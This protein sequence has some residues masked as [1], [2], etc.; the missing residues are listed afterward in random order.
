MSSKLIAFCVALCNLSAYGQQVVPNLELH[1]DKYAVID[2]ALLKVTYAFGR[3][4][5][6]GKPEVR[7]DDTHVVLIGSETSRHY[8]GPF[9]EWAEDVFTNWAYK[10]SVYP[11]HKLPSYRYDFY[12]NYPVHGTTTVVDHGNILN[13]VY[14]YEDRCEFD[15]TLHDEYLEILGYRCRKATA[16]FRGRE[17]TAWFAADVVTNAKTA[18]NNTSWLNMRTTDYFG[19]SDNAENRLIGG[20]WK[21]EGLPGLILKVSD[22]ENHYSWEAISVEKANE[23]IKFYDLKYTKVSRSEFQ[24]YM[25]SMAN[26]IAAFYAPRGVGTAV[27][28]KILEHSPP[29]P[30]NPIE[31]E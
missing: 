18:A 31:R 10:Q 23:P 17:W 21:F 13:Y 25:V 6:V 14:L 16:S 27:G 1:M 2:N 19:R 4:Q 5:D 15:W 11:S 30:Y 7:W 22:A 12:R 26:D 20:P 24:G 3:V 8:S 28:G 9:M 29:I